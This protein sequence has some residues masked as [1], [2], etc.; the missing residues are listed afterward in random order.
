MQNIGFYSF[1]KRK[2]NKN[3]INGMYLH[4]IFALYVEVHPYCL[5][6]T[7]FPAIPTIETI[8]TNSND[9]ENNDQ[10]QSIQLSTTQQT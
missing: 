7:K 10:S 4:P 5:F 9:N 6:S 8:I 1:K 3:K 2:E